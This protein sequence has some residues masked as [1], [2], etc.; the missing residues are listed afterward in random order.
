MSLI[1]T[2]VKSSG[3][4]NLLRLYVS[5]CCFFSITDLILLCAL[6]FESLHQVCLEVKFRFVFQVQVIGFH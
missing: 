4:N 5:G 6:L 2:L 1:F 3:L